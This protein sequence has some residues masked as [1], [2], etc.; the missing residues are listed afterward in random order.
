MC[1][2][3][4]NYFSVT[5]DEEKE[6]GSVAGSAYLKVREWDLLLVSTLFRMFQLLC[7]ATPFY[8]NSTPRLED[9]LLLPVCYSALCSG[10]VQIL[11]EP[12]GYQNGPKRAFRTQKMGWLWQTKTRVF[13]LV[14]TPPSRFADCSVSPCKVFA[15]PTFACELLVCFTK[16]WRIGELDENGLAVGSVP[17]L[18]SLTCFGFHSASAP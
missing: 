14:S 2:E 12:S 10:E 6:E 13:T 7:S 3:Y 18:C 4:L 15:S 8:F 11:P 5:S 17:E 9:T 16:T 1:D